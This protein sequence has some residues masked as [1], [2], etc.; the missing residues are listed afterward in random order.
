MTGILQKQRKTWVGL[1]FLSQSRK[2]KRSKGPLLS[3]NFTRNTGRVGRARPKFA[4]YSGRKTSLPKHRCPRA[5][6]W[7]RRDS[8]GA[9][10]LRGPIE[11]GVMGRH[12]GY[13]PT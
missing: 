12:G 5:Y 10:D 2:K 8:C 3:W 1:R 7:P 6:G 13:R 4:S 11:D 9:P